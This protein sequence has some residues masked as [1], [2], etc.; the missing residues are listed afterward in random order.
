MGFLDYSGLQRLK[1]KL[2]ALFATKL[3]ASQKGAANGVAELNSSGKVPSSQLPSYVDDVIEVSTYN[4]LPLEGETGKIYVTTDSNNSYRWS[5]S[6]YVQIN[7]VDIFDGATSGTSG[8]AGL[9]PAPTAGSQGKF[10]KGDGSWGDVPNPQTMQGATSLIDGE[11]GLVP[12]PLAGDQNKFLKANGSWAN[13]PNP[14]IMTGAT[15]SADGTSGLVPVPVAGDQLKYLR[16][17]GEWESP[18]GYKLVVVDL[19][20]ITNES[21]P[22]N[23]TTTIN[24]VTADMKPVM[25]EGSNLSAFKSKVNITTL[26]NGVNLTCTN[27]HGSTS[28]KVSLMMYGSEAAGSSSIT[29]PEFD[30]L[31]ARIQNVVSPFTGATA[32]ANGEAG[33]VPAPTAGN[34]L[35]YLRA[36]GTWNMPLG[37]K[38]IVADL[39]EITNASG[40]YSHTTTVAGVTAD[41]KPVML[42]GSDLSIF[43]GDVTITTSTN[44]VTLA[45]SDISGSSTVKVSLMLYGD[46]A[47]GSSSV[48]SQE[49]DILATR[50]SNKLDVAQGVSHAGKFLVVNSSGNVEPIT[51]TAW[52]GGSY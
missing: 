18:A 47:S 45:C 15:A 3:D 50:I 13:V 35:K 10:L 14:Q 39:D 29:S 28:V 22:Y 38:L 51:M 17:D 46:A 33:I 8:S 41:M 5:G 20:S 21:G 1:S 23:H 26:A 32:Q 30:A 49:F 25:L 52:Q 40:T 2:D 37:S 44:A 6:A 31:A 43:N 4:D 27:I 48:S 42:E 24:G 19:D 36:D 16:G 11:E 12:A 7:V 34:Q 9:V